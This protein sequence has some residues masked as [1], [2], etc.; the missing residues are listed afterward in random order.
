MQARWSRNAGWMGSALAVVALVGCGMVKFP[1]LKEKAD[2]KQAGDK[3]PVVTP[4]PQPAQVG[5]G[6]KGKSYGGGI[7]TEPASQ[8]WKAKEQI[9]FNIQIPSGM[10]TFKALNDRAP[11]SHEE[12][13]EKIINE[14]RIELPE[15]PPGKRYEYDPQTEQLMVITDPPPETE[16]GGGS[17][18]P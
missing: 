10:N 17:S 11:A 7:I 12:F 13:M 15:L 16:S 14:G 18:E 5:V 1:E 2:G 3:Q 8:Y 9:A 6:R 4:N